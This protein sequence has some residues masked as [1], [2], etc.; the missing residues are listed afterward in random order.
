MKKL[1]KALVVFGA[2]LAMTACQTG[3]SSKP[4]E[5]PD[6]KVTLHGEVILADGT[7]NGWNGKAKELYEKTLMTPISV[8]DAKAINADVGALLAKR[9]VKYLYKYEG[10]QF[11]HPDASDWKAYFAKDG[12]FYAADASFVFKAATLNYIEE[13]DK[14]AE[15]Q[16]IP[17]PKTAHVESLTPDTYFTPTWQEAPDE[18]GLSWASNP[19]V[20]G[21]AG[22]YTVIVAQYK[23]VS[24][25]DV[26]GF[27][28]AAIKTGELQLPEGKEAR[29]YSDPMT[30]FVVADHTYGLVGSFPESEWGGHADTPMTAVEGQEATFEGQ[31]T[32]AADAEV[33]VRV[34]GDWGVSWG[35]DSAKPD[36]AIKDNFELPEGGNIKVKV[37]GTYKFTLKVNG[38]YLPS[39]SIKISA[40]A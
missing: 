7:K 33:K 24:A 9:N 16:W 34:D 20:T 29:R 8:K 36:A 19:V 15:E 30:K 37:A 13:D 28:V 23:E 11:G 3:G 12:K 21:G 5:D 2:A 40:V 17:D 6:H 38:G 26:C 32:L 25:A 18:Y 22:V 27:G 31:L 4:L 10:I 14:Y 39:A 35:A 1:F